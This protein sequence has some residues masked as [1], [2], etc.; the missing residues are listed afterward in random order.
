MPPFVQLA[1][2][3]SGKDGIWDHRTARHLLRRAGCGAGNADVARAVQQGMGATVESLLAEAPEQEAEFQDTFQR[4]SGQ[5][6]DFSDAA[7]LQ[8]WWVYRMLRTR[9]PLR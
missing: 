7:Q 1:P 3:E 9:T 5:F 4:I 6:A 8:S 2:F